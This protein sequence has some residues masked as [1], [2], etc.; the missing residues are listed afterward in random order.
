MDWLISDV[1]SNST[2][3]YN[4]KVVQG[5]TSVAHMVKLE[6][7]REDSHGHRARKTCEF[8]KCSVFSKDKM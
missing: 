3:L 7:Y 5:L 2:L 6:Q 4:G 1:L 8:V